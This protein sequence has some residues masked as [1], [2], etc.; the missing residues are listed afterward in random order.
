MPETKERRH[1][2]RTG[3]FPGQKDLAVKYEAGTG[4]SV[5][6]AK[7]VEYSNDGMRIELA[8]P[9]QEGLLVEIVGDLEGAAGPMPLRQKGEVMRCIPIAEGRY[10]AG[11]AFL[12]GSERAKP[13]HSARNV[14]ADHYEVLQLSR[15]ASSDT[16]QR[17]FRMLAKRYHPDN[18]E[19]GN[20]EL[21]RAIVEAA[22][23]LT[24]PQLR[25]AYDARLG[26]QN[27]NRFKIFENWQTSRGVEA[28]KRKRKGVLALLYGRRITDPHEPTLGLRE[29]EQML[30]CPREHLEFTLWF[31]KE[32]K[33]VKSYDNGYYEITCQGVLIAEEDVDS[34]TPPLPLLTAA[35]TENEET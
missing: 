5:T 7:L 22:R 8:G 19:T 3:P 14:E 20:P 17:V 12:L 10:V 27:R 28:E 34:V 13:D 33:W 26:V 1:S 32:N 29:L 16:I 35:K 9:L 23:V 2:H 31:L 21:F 18:P 6:P 30:D 4:P 11:I 24:D 25:A 15:N